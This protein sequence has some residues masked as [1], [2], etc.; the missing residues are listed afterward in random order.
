MGV[1]IKNKSVLQNTLNVDFGEIIVFIKFGTDWCIPCQE[2]DK[3]VVN[4][5][6]SVVYNVN[7]DDDEF[8]NVMDEYN[9]K[10]IPYTIIKYK[11]ETRHFSGGITTEQVNRLIDDIKK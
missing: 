8:E 3:I 4:V 5:P 1:T 11:K 6:N 10:T 9:F 7:I 2:L